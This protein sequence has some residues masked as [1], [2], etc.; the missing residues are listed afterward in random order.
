MIGMQE[1][2]HIIILIGL[3]GGVS[4]C[5][6]AGGVD[7][8]QQSPIVNSQS[9]GQIIKSIEFLGNQHFK[10]HVLRQ[11][12]GFELGDRLD[13][14]L[15]EG[16]RTTIA[17]VYRKI[18]YAFVEVS[19]DKDKASRGNLLYTIEEGP[20]VQVSGIQF[21]G[22][23]AYSS[24][25]LKKIIKTT[26][27]QWL[28][29]PTY[30]TEDAIEEDVGRL[31][32]F[33]YD[34]G[35][36][37]YKIAAE[38]EFSDD[39]ATVYITF[40]IAEGPPY[41]IGEIRITGNTRYSTEELMAHID[42]RVD[43]VYL[44]PTARKD[45]TAIA[46]LYREQGFVDADVKQSVLMGTEPGSAVVTLKF[47][48]T[49]GRPFRIGRVEVTGNEKLQDKTVR[50][51]L[52]EYGFT[53]GELYNAK[54]APKDGAGQLERFVRMQTRSEEVMIRPV[55]PFDGD[56]NRRNARVDVKEGMTGLI[57][58]SVGVSSD[59]G[60]F[61]RLV[62][63]QDNFDIFGGPPQD[64]WDFLTMG[65][66]RGAGQSLNL[67]L[68][69]GTEYSQY[70][71][72]WT[73]PYWLDRPLSLDVLGRS[74]QRYRESWDESRLK[75]AVAVEQRLANRWRPSI[76]FR[77]ENVRLYRLD[78]DV[79]QE[80]KD[81]EGYNQL[82][83]LKFGLDRPDIDDPFT[84]SKGTVFGGDYEQVTGDFDFGIL[85]G[86]VTR[87]WTLAEDIV[88]RKTV[89]AGRVLAATTVGDAPT[90]EKF[91]A[92][93]ANGPYALRG[94][95]YRGISPR[96]LQT[97]VDPSSRKTQGPDRQRLDLPGRGGGHYPAYRRQLLPAV[98]LRQRYG[99]D[100]QV[101]L[102]RWYRPANHRAPAPRTGA[103]AVR[104]CGAPAQRRPGQDPG[105]QL[106]D[107]RDV[108]ILTA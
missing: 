80:I 97:G 98:L 3:M 44:R 18:G 35:Y 48:V 106:F 12:L 52:D 57:M 53:P 30:Y 39:H 85:S 72:E 60:V 2:K 65:S 92:G 54:M 40:T 28:V 50:H 96:G 104:N 37:N 42:A 68:E 56:P 66:Y 95:R 9:S 6:A 24:G 99:R 64:F 87:Y 108:W 75:G 23:A 41:V 22:N 10:D 100:R 102:V 20:R 26:T 32:D 15:A 78:S 84:P 43:K 34:H 47:D 38:K 88:G 79:P 55:A 31:R 103:D 27:K 81:E 46:Q 91:Y 4:P 49:E 33:Y 76:G 94:F 1:A 69:P 89:L 16:G 71:V 19:L 58:P 63:R 61:G 29:W 8:N 90:F 101:P 17:E 93:G 86:H 59:S 45:A 14:F 67:T 73:D 13:P 70:F 5:M 25:T 83:G 107:G 21:I 82:Y 7:P 11:R 36:L 51:V 105:I 77:A 62:Y 74:W